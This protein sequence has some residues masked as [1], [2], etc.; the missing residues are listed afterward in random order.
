[1]LL[2]D[3]RKTNSTLDKQNILSAQACFQIGEMLGS[4]VNKIKL[5]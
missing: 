5:P 3:L 4:A 1:M 2:H